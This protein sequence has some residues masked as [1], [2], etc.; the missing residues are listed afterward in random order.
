M[1]AG[2]ALLRAFIPA[3]QRSGLLWLIAVAV[4]GPW[5]VWQFARQLYTAAMHGYVMTG[6]PEGRLHR[7]DNPNLYRNNVIATIILLPIVAAGAVIMLLDALQAEH[8]IR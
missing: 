2:L 3:M 1:A 5:I 8:L 7:D 6:I 4:L